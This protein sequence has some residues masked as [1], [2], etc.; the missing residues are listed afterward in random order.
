MRLLKVLALAAVTAASISS[1][2][3]ASDLNEGTT[4][5][6]DSANQSVSL[7]WWGRGGFTYLVQ[8]SQDLQT[9]T[10]APIADQPPDVGPVSWGFAHP[11]NT[12]KQFFRLSLTNDPNDPLMLA[13]FDGDGISNY[14]EISKGMDI[15]VAEPFT[16]TDSDTL[17]DYWEMFYFGG[18]SQDDFGDADGDGYL[19]SVEYQLGMNPNQFGGSVS[20][21]AMLRKW[22]AISG[23]NI[24]NLT[25]ILDYVYSPDEAYQVT[26]IELPSLAEDNFGVRID[27]YIVPEETGSYTFWIVADDSGEFWLSSDASPLNVTRL[28]YTNTPTTATGWT[29]NPSQQSVQVSLTAGEKY[30]FFALAKEASGAGI[31]KVAWTKP[32]TTFE[33][34]PASALATVPPNDANMDGVSDL[35]ALSAAKLRYVAGNAQTGGVGEALSAFEVKVVRGDNDEPVV[36]TDVR[37]EVVSGSGEF[38][39]SSTTKIVQTDANGIASIIY[40]LGTSL[41]TTEQVRAT[42]IDLAESPK[43]K[44][45][46]YVRA[47]PSAPSS[48]AMVVNNVFMQ[49]DTPLPFGTP[50]LSYSHSQY[51]LGRPY[52]VNLN[53]SGSPTERRVGL[54]GRP[55]SD[56]TPENE[57]ETDQEE[58]ETYIDAMTLELRHDTTDIYV[59]IPNSDLS[60]SVRRN[61]Q[62]EIWNGLFSLRPDEKVNQ[63]FGACWSSNIVPHVELRVRKTVSDSNVPESAT[64]VDEN[65]MTHG[66][67]IQFDNS[68]NGGHLPQFPFLNKSFIPQSRAR[69]QA[70]NTYNVLEHYESGGTDFLKLTKKYGTVIIYEVI[71]GATRSLPIDD[72]YASSNPQRNGGENYNS[73]DDGTRYLYARAVSVEDRFGNKLV[74]SYDDPSGGAAKRSLLPRKIQVEGR[75]EL[76]LLIEPDKNSNDQYIPRVKRIWD[77]NNNVVEYTYQETDATGSYAMPGELYYATTIGAKKPVRYAELKTVS[78][79]DGSDKEY[80]Y[81]FNYENDNLSYQQYLLRAQFTG[82]TYG[83]GYYQNFHLNLK[84]ITDA[85]KNKW[86]FDYAFKDNYWN[87]RY[88]LQGWYESSGMPRQVVG[89]DLPGIGV[90]NQADTVFDDLS[91]YKLN[92]TYSPSHPYALPFEDTMNWL[93]SNFGATGKRQTRFTDAEGNETTYTWFDDTQSIGTANVFYSSGVYFYSLQGVPTYLYDYTFDVIFTELQVDYNDGNA[94]YSES[95]TYSLDAGLALESK[96][97]I[98]DNTTSY[99]YLDAYEYTPGQ[100]GATGLRYFDLIDSINAFSILDFANFAP[101]HREPNKVTDALANVSYSNYLTSFHELSGSAYS[102]RLLSEIRDEEGRLTT[103]E[104]DPAGR[105]LRCKE[106]IYADSSVSENQ[107]TGE[108]TLTPVGDPVQR[109]EFEYS[110]TFPSFVKK[111]TL[112]SLSGDPAWATDLVTEYVPDANGRIAEEIV[113]P[114]GL[115]LKTSYTYDANG[116]RKSITDP[117]SNTTHFLYDVRNRLTHTI[118]PDGTY[119]EYKYDPRSN[120]VLVINEL[121]HRIGYQYDSL[122]RLVRKIVDM[123][124]PQNLAYDPNQ[125]DLFSGDDTSIDLI[126][127]NSY[128]DVNSLRSVTDANGS[129]TTHYYDDLQ[130][131]IA[132]KTPAVKTFDAVASVDTTSSPAAL[133]TWFHYGENSGGGLLSPSS[134]RPTHTVDAR[135]FVSATRYDALFRATGT[136]VQYKGTPYTPASISGSSVNAPSFNPSNFVFPI[137]ADPNDNYSVTTIGFDAVDNAILQTD[138]AGHATAMDYDALNR[139][140]ETRFAV[141]PSTPETVNPNYGK[142][143]AAYTATGLAYSLTDEEGRQT[144]TEYD[145]AGRPVLTKQPSVFDAI[146]GSYQNPATQTLYDAASNVSA[147]INPLGHRWDY[148][149]DARNRQTHELQPAV[150]DYDTGNYHRPTVVTQYDAVGNPLAQTDPRGFTTHTLFDPANRPTDT[151]TPPVNY[152]NDADAITTGVHLVTR[153]IFDKNGNIAE[154]WQGNATA[155]TRAATTLARKNVD[156]VWDALNRLTQTTDAANITVANHYDASGNRSVVIDGASQ[157]TEFHYDGLNR[158]TAIRYGVAS[159]TFINGTAYVFD[160]LNQRGRYLGV[161][162]ISTGQQTAYGYDDRNRL[163]TVDYAADM[164]V[165]RDYAYD[166]VGNILSVD[167]PETLADAA[168]T[169]DALNRQQTETSAGV[170]HSYHYDLAGNRVLTEYG[171]PGGS[172]QRRLRSTYDALN[173]TETIYQDDNANAVDDYFER[174]STYAYDLAGNIRLKVQ[175]NGDLIEKHFDA[176]N[177]KVLIDGPLQSGLHLYEY[178]FTYDLYANLAKIEETYPGGELDDRTIRNLHD[179]ADRLLTET[180]ATGQ[181][182]VTTTY[183]YNNA[184]NRTSKTITRIDGGNPMETLEANTY[185]FGNALNQIDASYDS[186]S[187][188]RLRYAYSDQGNREFRYNDADNSGVY[189]SGEDYTNYNFDEENRLQNLI[190]YKDAATQTYAYQYDYRTRRTLRDE[191]Q[192]NGEA[193][194]IVFSGGTSA[195]EWN[196][197]GTTA[198]FDSADTLEVENIRGSDYGGG[199][200]GLLYTLREGQPSFKHYNSRGDVVAA[201][202]ALGVLTYQAAYE[203]FGKHTD[204][205]PATQEWGDSPDRQRH[206]TKDEDPHGLQYFHHRYYDPDTGVFI[207]PDPLGFVDGPNVYTYVVQNPWTK[208]DPLGLKEGDVHEVPQITGSLEQIIAHTSGQLHSQHSTSMTDKNPGGNEHAV[209]IFKDSGTGQY[210]H[211]NVAELGP[212]SGDTKLAP[213]PS[214]S[215]SGTWEEVGKNH[216]HPFGVDADSGKPPSKQDAFSDVDKENTPI[217]QF[218][219]V[220]EMDTKNVFKYNQISEFPEE[221]VDGSHPN[222]D[223]SKTVNDHLRGGTTEHVGNLDDMNQE[224]QSSE[225]EDDNE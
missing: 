166:K 197:D 213:E 68:L 194:Y 27:G 155:P 28:A 108:I 149:H 36:G 138:A 89:V 6:H 91:D 50:T 131:L 180:I 83:A 104:F 33:L 111:R 125:A 215:A 25:G 79:D 192:A 26:G 93:P 88:D 109:T 165:D 22:S 190:Q 32:D 196:E 99:S 64:V 16:N 72:R 46:S 48:S 170:E 35:D 169:Y 201:T 37:F 84:S 186:I 75:P 98:H 148:V 193:S 40:E 110:S 66:Y 61:Y 14:D 53:E 10:W 103:Y 123:S 220:V 174:T 153:Q 43:F 55:L 157:R 5:V 74:Y 112:K 73:V 210:S 134:F 167:E 2:Q 77:P 216:T 183:G 130:R 20:G 135:G 152:I 101:T 182:T 173:R 181:E 42:A 8:Q 187:D 49:P 21:Y 158:N 144:L 52:V 151:F 69:H 7:K 13:D 118:H 17:A 224:T 63:P 150:E 223:P 154:T 168:Y 29:T 67:L 117:R 221:A 121:G 70:N 115:A 146:S 200:G 162:P 225:E 156:N 209:R 45:T 204:E 92:L 124:E 19:N 94:N 3:T 97:D 60:L 141:N 212:T 47:S 217:G 56:R 142:T 95:F 113:D 184:H 145:A 129:S 205:G 119:Q 12:T 211:G 137:N 107:T 87:Y 106:F 214:S 86:V 76:R 30:Y 122:N 80:T 81:E 23:T 199:V 31:L 163:D 85:N 102:F 100:T 24:V 218:T 175:P 34:V 65:G 62:T 105:G 71:D 198:G 160:D 188:K 59:P 9:W 161:T 195:Q 126:T 177:R 78:F 114:D 39:D 179:G 11:A 147:V 41:G 140:T 18:L 159:G 208:F 120:R 116:N 222:F 58:E 172:I 191:S 38:S 57:S 171:T 185:S 4:V 132:I 164:V 15:F 1:A 82:N 189:E 219:A 202:D 127:Y 136:A 176:L 54:N 206:S 139:P 44:F 96:T 128:N 133:V 178:A 90:P 203:A 51:V 143:T 207:S